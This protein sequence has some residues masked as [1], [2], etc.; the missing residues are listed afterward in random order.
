[1]LKHMLNY[2]VASYREEMKF[3]KFFVP[4]LQKNIGLGWNISNIKILVTSDIRAN[5]HELSQSLKSL[6][7]STI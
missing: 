4:F 1:M 7:S 3:Y 5:Y 6:S 2:M